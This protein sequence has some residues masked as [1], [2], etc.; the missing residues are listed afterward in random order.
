[1]KIP[2]ISIDTITSTSASIIDNQQF[3]TDVANK[4]SKENS[5]LHDLLIVTSKGEEKSHDFKDGYHKGACLIY[6]LLSNQIEAEDMNEL[7][8]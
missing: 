2:K 8:G 7:W 5:L 4:I 3:W 1:M 6:I